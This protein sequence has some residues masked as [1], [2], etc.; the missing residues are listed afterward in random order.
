M[1]CRS[2]KGEFE[3][4]SSRTWHWRPRELTGTAPPAPV[5]LL[6]L[7]SRGPASRTPTRTGSGGRTGVPAARAPRRRGL[8]G[9]RWRLGSKG[10]PAA[11]APPTRQAV[12][13]STRSCSSKSAS[14]RSG[15][16]RWSPEFSSRSSPCHVA[17]TISSAFG[18]GK[19]PC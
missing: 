2:L 18:S 13:E 9:R 4:C 10:S 17:G 8:G 15:W 14:P 16:P 1:N 7:G 6:R 11:K 19:L 12:A 3:F 5:R